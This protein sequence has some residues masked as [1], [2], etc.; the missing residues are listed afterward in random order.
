MGFVD[1]TNLGIG[2]FQQIASGER[3]KVQRLGDTGRG[4]EDLK[5]RGRDWG[6]EVGSTR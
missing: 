6:E 1:A 3:S 4:G 2:N 5:V